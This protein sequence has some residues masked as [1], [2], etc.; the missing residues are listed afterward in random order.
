MLREYTVSFTIEVHSPTNTSSGYRAAQVRL[1]YKLPAGPC[2]KLHPEPLALIELFNPFTP[3]PNRDTAL[4]SVKRAFRQ[5][6]RHRTVVPLS[7]I[8]LLCQLTPIHTGHS[9]PNSWINSVDIMENGTVFTLNP[10]TSILLHSA[11]VRSGIV[12]LVGQ[13]EPKT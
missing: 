9:L 8:H 12:P 2:L 11:F 10:F 5:N 4:F 13:M 7:R 1:I 6:T 3:M